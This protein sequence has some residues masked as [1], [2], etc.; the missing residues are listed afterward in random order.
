MFAVL[1]TT[2]DQWTC[3]KINQSNFR[4]HVI[5]IIDLIGSYKAYVLTFGTRLEENNVLL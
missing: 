4:I 5:T 2:V 1:P 3:S